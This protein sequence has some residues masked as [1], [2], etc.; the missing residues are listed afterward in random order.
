MFNGY[1]LMLGTPAKRYALQK[2]LDKSLT[3]L[4]VL[5]HAMSEK[6]TWYLFNFSHSFV[7]FIKPNQEM[8]LFNNFIHYNI[9]A[10]AYILLLYGEFSPENPNGRNRN[11]SLYVTLSGVFGGVASA[12]NLITN[13]EVVVRG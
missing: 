7:T 1:P 2:E 10:H 8:R 5:F 11:G 3:P 9:Q 13:A 6:K 4:S 12:R